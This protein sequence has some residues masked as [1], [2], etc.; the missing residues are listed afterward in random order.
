M[1]KRDWKRHLM[2]EEK[3]LLERMDK[4]IERL[5]LKL[6]LLTLRR[7]KLQNRATARAKP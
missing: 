3:K 2:A 6:S 5:R 1:A 7:N 4:E